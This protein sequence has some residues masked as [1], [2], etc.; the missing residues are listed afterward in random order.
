VLQHFNYRRLSDFEHAVK[1]GGAESP[2]REQRE[3]QK[4]FNTFFKIRRERKNEG[5]S[6]WGEGPGEKSTL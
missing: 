1:G 4:G 6:G 2:S 3:F 5:R